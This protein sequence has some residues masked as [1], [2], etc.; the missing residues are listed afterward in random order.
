MTCTS[1]LISAHST[2]FPDVEGYS[3]STGTPSSAARPRRKGV[4]FAEASADEPR[5]NLSL[6]LV[7]SILANPINRPMLLKKNR[8]QLEEVVSALESFLP[9]L[10]EKIKDPRKLR[11]MDEVKKL[12]LAWDSLVRLSILLQPSKTVTGLALNREI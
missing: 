10:E 1:S 6:V 3:K 7:Q 2:W 5:P 11:D 4:R 12:S 9:V 8:I